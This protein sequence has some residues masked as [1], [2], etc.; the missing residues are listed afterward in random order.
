M[1]KQARHK[2]LSAKELEEAQICYTSAID[3]IFYWYIHKM[4]KMQVC[5]SVKFTA[6]HAER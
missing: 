4:N 3:V 6:D 5:S 1:E 2:T